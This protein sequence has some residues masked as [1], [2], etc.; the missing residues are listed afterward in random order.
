MH[1]SDQQ[2]VAMVEAMDIT[3]QYNTMTGRQDTYLDGENVES[4][5]RKTDAMENMEPI[6]KCQPVRDAMAR[7]QRQYG[8]TGWIVADWRDMGTVVYPDADLKIFLECELETRVRRR[9]KQLQEQWLP[10]DADAIR[11]ETI[12]RDQIDYLWPYAVGKKAD[13]AIVVDTT[14]MTIEGQIR[15]IVGMAL[16]LMD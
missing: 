7:L 11:K 1:A 10:A 4:L 2:K 6:V 13:D 9:V 3:R 15:E 8:E 12:E 14:H 16:P 5:I